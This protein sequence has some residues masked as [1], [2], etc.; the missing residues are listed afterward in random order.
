MPI[1]GAFARV[2]PGAADPTRRRLDE[3]EGVTTF[4]L[5]EP[6]K[7]GLLLET[8]DLEAAHV[9]VRSTIRAVPGVM[10]VWPVYVNTEDELEQSEAP[11]TA[12]P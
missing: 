4:E 6:G 8:G 2:D 10:G 3:L 9:L 12:Q 5:D 1:V 7:V 11:V